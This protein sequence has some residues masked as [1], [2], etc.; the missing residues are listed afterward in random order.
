MDAPDS[1]SGVEL[2]TFFPSFMYSGCTCTSTPTA[3]RK[4]KP[5]SDSSEQQIAPVHAI[6]RRPCKSM[7]IRSTVSGDDDMIMESTGAWWWL[8]V[9]DAFELIVSAG[10][11][12]L[13][14]VARAVECAG[15]KR[16]ARERELE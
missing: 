1:K 7:R 10:V 13:T 11:V 16:D 4:K 8:D 3:A 15:R 6:R 2:L 14:V 9:Q 12:C 5:K